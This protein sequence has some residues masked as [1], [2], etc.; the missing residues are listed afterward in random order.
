MYCRVERPSYLEL[1]F[2]QMYYKALLPISQTPWPTFSC[3]AYQTGQPHR[4]LLPMSHPPL[5]V[6]EK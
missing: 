2:L 1:V 3:H 6:K 5:E 4:H